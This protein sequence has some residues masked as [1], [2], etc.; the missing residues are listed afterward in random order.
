[1]AAIHG[2]ELCNVLPALYHLTGADYTS[3]VGTKRSALRASPQKFLVN[4]AQGI[5]IIILF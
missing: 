2:P 4:F 3:K 1:M 5:E